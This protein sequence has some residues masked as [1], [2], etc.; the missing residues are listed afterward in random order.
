MQQTWQIF[1]W[2]F[3]ANKMC[4]SALLVIFKEERS[5]WSKVKEAADSGFSLRIHGNFGTNH[6][7]FKGNDS[8]HIKLHTYSCKLLV[9][10]EVCATQF[11]KNEVNGTVTTTTHDNNYTKIYLPPNNAVQNF[12]NVMKY[13]ILPNLSCLDK[14][15]QKDW[16]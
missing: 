15:I 10:A 4:N 3:F 8:I 13:S 11:V 12:P 7:S 16:D 6:H 14:F 5:F 1:N 9:C 2:T